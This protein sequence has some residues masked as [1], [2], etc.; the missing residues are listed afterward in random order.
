MIGG[1]RGVPNITVAELKKMCKAKGIRGYSKYNKSQLIALLHKAGYKVGGRPNPRRVPHPKARKAAKPKA[2]KAV[3]G[4]ALKR[5]G[6]KRP[7]AW[8]EHVKHVAASR[9]I[10][11]R[12]AMKIASKTYRKE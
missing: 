9:G 10:P 6:L 8:V 4:G 7:N 1:K 2:K 3:K 12:E 11:Y 5:R